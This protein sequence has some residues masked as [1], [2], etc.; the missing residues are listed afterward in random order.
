MLLQEESSQ[1]HQEV[2][3]TPCYY[4]KKAPGNIRRGRK[5]PA[6][7]GEVSDTML[8]QEESPQAIS[9]EVSDTMLLQ[10]ESP[11]AT[12]GEVSDTMLLQEESPQATSGEVSDTMLLQE[13]SPEQHQERQETSVTPCYY[14][15]KAPSNIRRCQ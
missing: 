7:S 15:K 4:M 6:T 2:S 5:L 1:Q 12:S 3:V 11:Q 14:R 13:E 9:G 8:L 10:E